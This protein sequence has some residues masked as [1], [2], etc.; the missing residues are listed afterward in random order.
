MLQ[1]S[2]TKKM[3]DQKKNLLKFNNTYFAYLSTFFLDINDATTL[4]DFIKKLKEKGLNAN[5]DKLFSEKFRIAEEFLLP[6]EI[7]KKRFRIKLEDFTITLKSSSKI[8]FMRKP[9]TVEV[10]L[11]VYSE[12]SIGILMF[13]VKLNN[14]ST[15]DL[16]LVR[17]YFDGREKIK[18]D[19]Y[20]SVNSD[21]S[22]YLTIK[23]IINHYIVSLSKVFKSKT[24]PEKTLYT[25][26][27]EIG[28]ANNFKTT[29]PKHIVEKFPKQLY[30]LLTGDEGW[31]FVPK[32]R[33]EE[34]L[35]INWTTRDF[36]LVL[37]FHHC[38]LLLN[39]KDSER[40]KKYLESCNSLTKSY[41][42]KVEDYFTFSPEIA[43]LNH[44]PLLILENA[45][46]ERFLL[47]E[48]LEAKANI[49]KIKIS[50]F[51]KE[52]DKI[53]E[54]LNKLSYIDIK[55][56]REMS[57][58]INERMLIINDIKEAKAKLE[59]FEG[60]IL[61]KYNQRIN[62]LIIFLTILGLVVAGINLIKL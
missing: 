43:G 37:S 51:L 3:P 44:G 38:V 1:K 42:K 6:S 5:W 55:E 35:S 33:A 17:Q 48:L 45:S 11:T 16:I 10:F 20:K 2:F 41:G 27:F 53:I 39:F 7:C 60:E 62:R 24:K 59:L 46:V 58:L 28:Q 47:N 40:Y 61:I 14:Y 15:D 34:I 50:N 36:L 56:I 29:N 13:N 32:K 30:G 23:E 19:L 26:I 8:D 54:T 49:K 57:W 12:L 18:T 25:N 9:L 4:E 21:K 52:R 31:R 22:S